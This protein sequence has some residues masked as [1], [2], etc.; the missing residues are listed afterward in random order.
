VQDDGRAIA[1]WRDG[2]IFYRPL[3]SGGDEVPLVT[4]PDHAVLAFSPVIGP[5]W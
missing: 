4:G 2:D 3:G 1:C 5:G